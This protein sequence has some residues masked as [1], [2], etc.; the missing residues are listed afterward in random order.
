[1]FLNAMSYR[2]NNEKD[3]AWR[4]WLR[5]NE[6]ALNKCGLPEIV[7]RSEAH[8]WDFLMHGYFDHHEDSSDFTVDDLSQAEMK[9]L[10]E[11]LGSELTAEEK[12]SAIILS[13]LES[14]LG[15]AASES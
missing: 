1:M 11:F 3:L 15:N 8:W 14:G 10:K 6:N 9:C 12:S 7:L 5:R 4:N 2:R 13:R